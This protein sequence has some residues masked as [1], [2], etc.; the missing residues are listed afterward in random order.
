VKLRSPL[1]PIICASAVVG[2]L[3]MAA[4]ATSESPKATQNKAA[5]PAQVATTNPGPTK[6]ATTTPKAPPKTTPKETP[7]PPPPG[8][9]QI[10]VLQTQLGPVVVGPGGRTLY[11]FDRDTNNPPKSNCAGGC[12][13]AWPPLIVNPTAG[14]PHGVDPKL[15]G[16]VTRA[17]GTKQVTL[18]G[19]PLYF[20]AG[21]SKPR[22]L[23]GEGVDGIWHAIAP[24][25]K[26]AAA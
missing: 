20:Y 17:D 15:L 9:V 22:D 24:T 14:S 21:D 1:I 18:K 19:W 5:P 11:R 8:T 25:G 2:Q 3:A 6:P 4:W 16:S 13:T 7:K 23:T 12:A 10:A 26:P